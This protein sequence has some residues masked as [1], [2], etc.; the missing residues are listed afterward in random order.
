MT[1]VNQDWLVLYGV[2]NLWYQRVRGIKF[3]VLWWDFF[4]LVE[5]RY[6]DIFWRLAHIIRDVLF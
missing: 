4:L 2:L 5:Y 6:D 3:L 1:S